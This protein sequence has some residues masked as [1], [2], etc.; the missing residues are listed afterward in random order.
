MRQEFIQPIDAVR[1]DALLGGDLF[2]PLVC[3]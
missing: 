3:L 1:R 2:G